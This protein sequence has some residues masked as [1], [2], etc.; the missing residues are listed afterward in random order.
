LVTHKNGNGRITLAVLGEKVDSLA[1]TVNEIKVEHD[2]HVEAGQSVV[3]RITVLETKVA[4]LIWG[5]PLILSAIA[6]GL[7]VLNFLR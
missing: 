2:A 3:T 1:R 4:V 6:V 5:L 7:G